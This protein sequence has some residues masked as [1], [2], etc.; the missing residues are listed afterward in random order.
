[1]SIS[2]T[3]IQTAAPHKD[4]Y[5]FVK[6]KLAP[7]PLRWQRGFASKYSRIRAEKGRQAANL[8]LIDISERVK[9]HF[10]GLG[11][12]DEQVCS[13]AKVKAKRYAERLVNTVC[14]MGEFWR[15]ANELIAQGIN[16]PIVRK[17][18]DYEAL[19]KRF[20]CEKWWRKA[21]RTA[22]SRHVEHEAIKLGMV[23][24][25]SKYVSNETLKRRQQQ[26]RRNNELLEWIVA[27]NEDGQEY[28][29]AELSALG[30]SNPEI[31]KNELMTRIRGMEEEA[32]RHGLVGEFMTMTCPSKYH[33]TKSVNNGFRIENKKY[34][35]YTPKEAQTYLVE[36]YARIRAQLGREGIK[37]IGFRVA[38]PHADACPHW[39]L[40]LFVERK[41]VSRMIAVFKEHCYREDAD[42]L[43]H[44]KAQR[45]RF[46]SK[47]IDPTKGSAAAYMAK[48]IAKN[49]QMSG[50]ED[51]ESHEGGSVNDNLERSVAW[52]RTWGIRQFQQQ[53]G[54]RIGVWRELRKMREETDL[55]ELMRPLWKAADS[56]EYGFF[57][58][59]ALNRKI[60]FLR[61]QVKKTPVYEKNHLA[62]DDKG[63]FVVPVWRVSKQRETG[64]FNRYGEEVQGAI[65]GL[66]IDG[67][68]LITR[69]HVWEIKQRKRD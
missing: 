5:D 42:E 18:A 60:E 1:M 44:W 6:Q 63:R 31:R 49:V 3:P 65:S 17:H 51:F 2:K 57:L 11:A 16:P 58:R 43:K 28:T 22:I 45:A 20:K 21:L 33:A 8:Y 61:E 25:K 52:A 55:P 35:N 29:L 39:H 47:S 48:Y 9:L 15:I 24:N 36:T 10:V 23:G 50:I 41:H 66:V 67:V 68:E 7:Y 37:P 46:Y 53:G 54:E 59:E 62:P 32:K 69:V 38:E 26:D 64:F 12:D 13:L 34:K 14:F 56:G 40:L 27:E 30:V 19:C 4:D